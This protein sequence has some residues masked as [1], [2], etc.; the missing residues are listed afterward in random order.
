M[1]IEHHGRYPTGGSSFSLRNIYCAAGKAATNDGRRLQASFGRVIGH[2]PIA[3]EKIK[4]LGRQY[5]ERYAKTLCL[6]LCLSETV[7]DRSLLSQNIV[8]ISNSA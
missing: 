6:H 2:R 8:V 4:L 3:Q 7:R 5:L 1:F